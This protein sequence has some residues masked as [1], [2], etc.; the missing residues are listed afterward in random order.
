[1]SGVLDMPLD[2]PVWGIDPSTKRYVTTVIPGGGGRFQGV[3][4][5]MPSGQEHRRLQGGVQALVV[6]L[7][8]LVEAFGKPIYV[9]LEQPFARGRNVH[10]QS[11]YFVAVGLIA[12][13]YVLG[14]YGIV[15]TRAPM[16]WRKAALGDGFGNA[17][18]PA[19]LAWAQGLGLEMD[20]RCCHGEGKVCKTQGAAHDH[21]DSL[22]L[23]VAAGNIW[24]Q[25]GRAAA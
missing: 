16:V 25:R 15:D 13:S 3:E 7:R 18:K 6:D 2:Q 20:C 12:L 24:M 5:T 11:F 17:P 10:P 1:M 8:V 23:A 21:A 9:L 4:T 22:G 14:D 19:V